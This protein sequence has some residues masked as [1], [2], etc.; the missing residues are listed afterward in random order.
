MTEQ[1][2]QRAEALLDAAV[3]E[4]RTYTAV[5]ALLGYDRATVS[6]VHR[7]CYPGDA[8]NVLA[9]VLARFDRIECPYWQRSIA[10]DECR[11]VWE[12]ATPSH[13]P[14]ALAHRRVCRTCAHR[15]GGGHG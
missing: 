9:A 8:A 10:Q 11:A 4:Y 12:G 7:G 1:E 13:D 3:A 5:A 14:A 2:R 6:T 15:T